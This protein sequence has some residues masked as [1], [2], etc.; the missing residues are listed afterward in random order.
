MSAELKIVKTG[1]GPVPAPVDMLPEIV[2]PECWMHTDDK[3]WVPL[4]NDSYSLPMCLNVS[5]GYWV[6]LLR[7]CTPGIVNRHRH[8]SPV[9]V[10]TLKGN[11]HYPERDWVASP[12]TYVFEAPGDVHTLCVPEGCDEM[13]FMANVKGALV[14]VDEMG[15]P[16]GYDDVFTRIAAARAHY[17]NIGLGGDY[18]KNFIR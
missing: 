12:G 18:V 1:P 4:G 14:Y 11:W 6:H 7:V 8:S 16:T 3:H 15:N 10:L 13:M 17:E 9:H 5:E 2:M